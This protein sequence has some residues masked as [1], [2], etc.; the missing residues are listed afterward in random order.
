M[1][2]MYQVYKILNVGIYYNTYIYIYYSISRGA[3]LYYGTYFFIST[4]VIYYT[5]YISV[6]YQYAFLIITFMITTHLKLIFNFCL[7]SANV[8]NL[9]A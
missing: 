6:T 3:S 7:L 1:Y 2:N 8:D 5:L 9:L 4:F